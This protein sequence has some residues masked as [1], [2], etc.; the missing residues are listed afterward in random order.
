MKK[1]FFIVAVMFFTSAFINAQEIGAR[2]GNSYA[3]NIAIDGVF[4]YDKTMR[5]HGDVSFGDYGIQLDALWDFMYE[6]SGVENLRWYAGGGVAALFGDLF[7]LGVAGEIGAEYR[8]EFPVSLSF[9]WRPIFTVVEYTD[10]SIDN[11]GLN[12]RY[13]F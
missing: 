2:F 11:F 4:T 3:G 9:D 6:L 13:V 12:I 8:F 10:F 7:L 5:I 1:L